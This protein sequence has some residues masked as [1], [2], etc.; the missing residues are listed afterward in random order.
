V[1][2]EQIN[3]N[4]STFGEIEKHYKQA[5]LLMPININGK[6]FIRP[7]SSLYQDLSAIL[8]ETDIRKRT[9]VKF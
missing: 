4:I 3:T 6:P 9:T 8:Q 7:L 2:Q 5:N 1:T